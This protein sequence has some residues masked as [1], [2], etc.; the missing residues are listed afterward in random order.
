MLAAGL[1]FLLPGGLLQA[2]DDGT[3][4]YPENGT[5]V[6]ATFSAT[7]P[8]T[9]SITW[10]LTG[11][12]E[13]DF[14]IDPESG[15]L[16]FNTPPNYES[17]MGG[18]QNDSNTYEITV[19]AADGNDGTATKAVMVKV[20]DVE[21]RATIELSTRQPVVGRGAIGNLGNDDEVVSGVRWM[22]EKKD[23][24]T[25]VDAMGTTT[26]TD[27]K[28]YSSTYTPVQNEINA[29]LRVGVEYID[30]DDDNQ[31]VAAVTVEQA[32]AASAGG[33]NAAPSFTEG[34][35]ASRTIAENDSRERCGGNGCGRSR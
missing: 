31:T 15:E 2:Q 1:L 30:S 4:E 10:S 25:W 29:E 22:W 34:A 32:V 12:D 21:E 3:I 6:V 16:E 23:G 8:D 20:T 5:A 24:A 33:T 18:S 7:D 27:A 17:P 11:T 35:T 26:S 9:D 13:A 28:P 19:M 14:T